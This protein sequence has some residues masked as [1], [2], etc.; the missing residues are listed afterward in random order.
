M[1]SPEAPDLLDVSLV[2]LSNFDLGQAE[3]TS[4]DAAG[5][6]KPSSPRDKAWNLQE[7]M[8]EEKT[9]AEAAGKAGWWPFRKSSKP[10]APDIEVDTAVVEIPSSQ[11][12]AELRCGSPHED[13]IGARSLSPISLG[14]VLRPAGAP[15]K[16]PARTSEDEQLAPG[17]VP[18][19]SGV[20]VGIGLAGVSAQQS[21]AYSART[22]AFSLEPDGPPELKKSES[23]ETTAVS[24]FDS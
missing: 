23:V 21:D 2:S 6:E 16:R 22:S 18:S 4:G 9:K 19:P 13:A 17:A 3:E 11:A 12:E 5:V 20:T 8:P 1:G 10:P 7:A 15:P 24:A 14:D